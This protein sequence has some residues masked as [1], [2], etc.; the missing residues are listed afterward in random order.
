MKSITSTLFGI[1]LE[2]GL[3]ASIDDPVT[4]YLP[5]LSVSGYNR[6][7][8]KDVLMMATG[9]NNSEDFTNPKA[10]IHQ[11]GEMIMTGVPSF[12]DYIKSLKAKPNIE[13]GSVFD[14]ESIN[15]QV[16]GLVIEKATRMPLTVLSNRRVFSAN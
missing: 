11:F 3:I 7:N 10:S 9:I 14:Y 15:T 8:L 4:K 16:L 5:D 2:E 12:T 1:A 6:I 13:P